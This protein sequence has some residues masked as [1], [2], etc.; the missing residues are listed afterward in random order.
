MSWLAKEVMSVFVLLCDLIAIIPWSCNHQNDVY[1]YLF[2]GSDLLLVQHGQMV[3]EEEGCQFVIRLL[4]IIT[5]LTLERKY[6]TM[7]LRPEHRVLSRSCLPGQYFRTYSNRVSQQVEVPQWRKF[8]EVFALFKF[9]N[10]K[11]RRYK[12]ILWRNFVCWKQT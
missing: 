3:K 2:F 5:R 12:Y 6:T 8:M 4:L 11:Q 7:I 9:T 1:L 10:L